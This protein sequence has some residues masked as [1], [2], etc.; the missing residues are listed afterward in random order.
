MAVEATQLRND[1]RNNE[2]NHSGFKNG[3]AAILFVV[4]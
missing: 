1:D 4:Q 2:E 3:L